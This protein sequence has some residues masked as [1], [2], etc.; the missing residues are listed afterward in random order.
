MY[1]YFPFWNEVFL[2]LGLGIMVLGIATVVIIRR[3]KTK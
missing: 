1:G 3:V 2:V